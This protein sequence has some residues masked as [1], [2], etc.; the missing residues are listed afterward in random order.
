MEEEL[1]RPSA[2]RGYTGCGGHLAR[3]IVSGQKKCLP[4]SMLSVNYEG[5]EAL[6]VLNRA[7]SIGSGLEARL[8]TFQVY[9]L[10]PRR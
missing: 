5:E 1:T 8:V 10:V 2:E 4:T 3:M 9:L 6:A 7:G